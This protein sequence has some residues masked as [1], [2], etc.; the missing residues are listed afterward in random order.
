MLRVKK[1]V[2]WGVLLFGTISI[3]AFSNKAFSVFQQQ[4][5]TK[6]SSKAYN[7]ATTSGR[8][9]ASVNKE[10]SPYEI[11]KCGEIKHVDGDILTFCLATFKGSTGGFYN[12]T[13]DLMVVESFSKYTLIH[14]ITHAVTLHLLKKEGN[15]DLA[16]AE[17]QEKMAY[18]AEN[19]LMQITAFSEDLNITSDLNNE[20]K[21]KLGLPIKGKEIAV[22]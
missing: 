13:K 17:I 8:I 11:K 14:E 6:G 20:K 4:K 16:N 2:F 18:N 15:F 21:M 19:L 5:A 22:K 12:P 3:L 10:V 9:D 1:F 7:L